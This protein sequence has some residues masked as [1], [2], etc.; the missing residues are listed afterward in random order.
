MRGAILRELQRPPGAADRGPTDKLR[1]VACKLVDKAV[2]GDIQAIKEVL[3]RI[4]GKTAAGSD[5]SDQGPRQ[6]NIRWKNAT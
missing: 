2:E 6:V 3:D 1:L 4:D 5:D